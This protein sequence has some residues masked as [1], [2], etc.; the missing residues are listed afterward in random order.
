MSHKLESPEEM[1]EGVRPKR[2]GESAR[3]EGGFAD[4]EYGRGSTPYLKGKHGGVEGSIA[5]HGATAGRGGSG[6]IGK[7][8]G[9]KG[10]SE[11]IAHPASHREF[12]MLGQDGPGTA[13]GED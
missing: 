7:G 10:H 5:K 6:I 12:E 2:G 8:D 1:G 9:F 11:D 4:G 13:G 3:E